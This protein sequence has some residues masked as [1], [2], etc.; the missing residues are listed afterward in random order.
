MDICYYKLSNIYIYIYQR[1]TV[2]IYLSERNTND[3]NNAKLSQLISSI[4]KSQ[5]IKTDLFLHKLDCSS[6]AV[7]SCGYI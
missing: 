3:N 4:P 6:P 2:Y 1:V 5:R 7:H